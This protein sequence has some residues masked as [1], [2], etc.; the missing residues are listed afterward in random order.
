MKDIINKISHMKNGMQGREV[1]KELQAIYD[2]YCSIL[3]KSRKLDFDDLLLK[4]KELLMLDDP[5]V[6]A[7]KERTAHILVDEFQDTNA[8]QVDIVC[9]LG[10]VHV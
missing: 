1:T 10:S 6:R 7:L 4:F 8:V 9:Q 5:R 3:E 2:S